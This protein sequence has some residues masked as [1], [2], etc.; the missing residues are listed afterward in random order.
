M[1]TQT[2]PRYLMP[3]AQPKQDCDIIARARSLVNA[4]DEIQRQL[5]DP[6]SDPLYKRNEHRQRTKARARDHQEVDTHL[7]LE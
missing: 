1:P 6:E 4:A 7:C 2:M 3:R 5:L